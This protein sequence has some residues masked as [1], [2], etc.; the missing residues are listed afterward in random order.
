[1]NLNEQQMGPDPSNIDS[2]TKRKI[3][4]LKEAVLNKEYKWTG[5]KTTHEP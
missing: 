5:G 2:L 4:E 1:M 3:L